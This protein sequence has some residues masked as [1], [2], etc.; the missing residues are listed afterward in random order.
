MAAGIELIATADGA[1]GHYD[2]T[3]LFNVDALGAQLVMLADGS[4]TIE[5]IAASTQA[6]DP[7]FAALPASGAAE[8][9]VQLGQ[10]GYLQ[11]QVYVALYENRA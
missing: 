9:F 11:N 3:H 1:Q 2:G 6:A 7:A 8:F 10:A 4:R 5:Q